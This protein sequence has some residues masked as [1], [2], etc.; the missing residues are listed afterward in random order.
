MCEHVTCD[1]SIL[2]AEVA[3]CV[4]VN[5]RLSG[6]AL[7]ARLSRTPHV[8]AWA[9]VAFI[10]GQKGHGG[11]VSILAHCCLGDAL[12]DSMS[13]R[14]PFLGFGK[15]ARER[16]E[17]IDNFEKTHKPV[18]YP[19]TGKDILIGELSPDGSISAATSEEAYK[20]WLEHYSI[21]MAR[22]PEV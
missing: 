21:P 14:Y 13:T 6:S 11:A 17:L 20:K 3:L 22:A 2:H 4:L 19:I 10:I 7:A 8:S 5:G 16:K 18:G 15:K 9:G 12:C 1:V